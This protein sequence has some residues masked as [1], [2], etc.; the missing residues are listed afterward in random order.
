M[1]HFFI[2]YYEKPV[3][4]MLKFFYFNMTILR[5][6]FLKLSSPDVWRLYRGR[7]NCENRILIINILTKLGN[8]K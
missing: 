2:V 5:I 4:G 3:V 1:V 7:A 6:V 8:V